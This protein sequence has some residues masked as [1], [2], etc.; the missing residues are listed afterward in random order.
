M[1]EELGG[2][3]LGMSLNYLAIAQNDLEGPAVAGE[4]FAHDIAFCEQHGFEFG[5]L[6]QRVNLLGIL[7]ELGRWQEIPGEAKK[8]IEWA[9][10]AHYR[11]EESWAVLELVRVLIPTGRVAEATTLV[12]EILESAR[13]E[14]NAELMRT[15]IASAAAAAAARGDQR[16]AVAFMSEYESLTRSHPTNRNL[17]LPELMRVCHWAGE[18]SLA[19]RVFQGTDSTV[20]RHRNAGV[21]ARALLAEMNGDLEVAVGLHSE[22]ADRWA[23]F[24]FIFEHAYSLLGGGRCLTVLG[25]REEAA[26]LLGQAREIFAG[27]TASA[28][29]AEADAFLRGASAAGSSST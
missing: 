13:S 25:R 8:V 2:R 10:K 11:N 28:L 5:A 9:R 16:E 12:A 1:S 18:R 14:K 29:V 19:A 26:P 7:F 15:A 3:V 17:D 4:T 21:S 20:P 27:L 6:V 22:A 24:G 23:G